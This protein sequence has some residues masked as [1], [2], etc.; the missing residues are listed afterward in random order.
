MLWWFSSSVNSL[1]IPAKIGFNANGIFS[2][3]SKFSSVIAIAASVF[4]LAWQESAIKEYGSERG[5]VF[6]HEVYIMFYRIICCAVM[7]CIPLMRIILP[8]MI[9]PSYYEAINYAPLLVI[10]A[11]LSSTYGFFGQMY[12]ATGK[13]KGAAVTTVWGVITNL[14]IIFFL[15]KYM[16]LWAPT[17]AT[18]CSAFT[19]MIMRYFQFKNDMQLTITKDLVVLLF[20]IILS[21]PVYY[22]GNIIVCL[23]YIVIGIVVSFYVNKKFLADMLNIVSERMKR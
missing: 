19:I 13:T 22:Y 11:G 4:N 5:K 7:L 18:V 8:N 21:L 14:T 10:G 1:W 9:D 23:I 20:L 6:F 12:S 17:L 15:T 3:A 16:N 2:V